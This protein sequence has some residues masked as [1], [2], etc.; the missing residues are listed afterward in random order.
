MREL[1]D[2]GTGP[3]PPPPPEAAEPSDRLAAAVREAAI[4]LGCF[5]ALALVGALV[6]WQVAS[7]PHYLVGPQGGAMDEEQL[8]KQVGIDGWYAVIAAVGG[9]VAGTVLALRFQRDLVLT[10][11]LLVLGGGLAAWVM[12]TVGLAVGP[13]D[14]HSLLTGAEQGTRVP[15]R[16][17]VT[18]PAVYLIWPV[19]ALLGSVGVV[20][21]TE[22]KKPSGTVSDDSEGA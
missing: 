21:G 2:T 18:M 4:V 22:P 15:I 8:S 19:A 11:V 13:P 20:W 5:A 7:L 9:L 17:T 10:V 1:T 16:L 14:P 3:E 12:R 6:W